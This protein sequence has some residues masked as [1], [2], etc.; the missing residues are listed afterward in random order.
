MALNKNKNFTRDSLNELETYFL[1]GGVM[2]KEEIIEQ[3]FPMARSYESHYAA[4]KMVMSWVATLKKRIWVGYNEWF[5]ALNRV[6][7]YGI[8]KT[9]G[10]LFFALN[11]YRKQ[12]MGNVVR[13]THLYNKG[14]EKKLILAPERQN[15]MLPYMVE[16]EEEK[17]K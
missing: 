17:K 6:G 12:V 2:T 15:L 7:Q 11:R 13:A 9:E 5:G 10:Q 14:V 4:N 1:D 8:P 16:P 3:Y